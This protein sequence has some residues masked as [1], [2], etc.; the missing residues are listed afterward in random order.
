MNIDEVTSKYEQALAEKNK[1]YEQINSLSG[2]I[3]EMDR[4]GIVPDSWAGSADDL[5][6]AM[7][8]AN[9]E[10]TKA[11]VQVNALY[12][13]MTGYQGIIDTYNTILTEEAEATNN[14]GKEAGGAF[15]EG[16][17]EGAE[18]GTG[19]AENA[20]SDVVG[21]AISAAKEKAES[22]GKSVGEIA[23]DA[24]TAAMESGM[25][26]S[27]LKKLVKQ[28]VSDLK[29]EQAKLGA[30][31]SWLYD[32]EEKMI[33]VLGEGSELY[34]EYMTTILNGRKKIADSAA[35]IPKATKRRKP[36]RKLRRSLTPWT[37]CMPR[38]SRKAR[39]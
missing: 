33:S 16:F 19:E 31:D 12:E 32:E 24:L 6:A 1:W 35:K 27:D 38:R 18:G 28:Y 29:Y 10:F 7:D 21:D 23:A 15:G 34:K 13:S 22:E 4:T 26:D 8:N 11:T 36:K 20:A 25:K 9:E 37:V 39:I 30:D 3:A 2:M 14:G 5:R 17:A